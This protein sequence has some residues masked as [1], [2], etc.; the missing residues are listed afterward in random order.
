MKSVWIVD[1]IDSETLDVTQ[2]GK[3]C[4]T[5]EDAREVFTEALRE[6]NLLDS[7]DGIAGVYNDEEGTFSFVIREVELPE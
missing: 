7:W 2:I 4:S 1:F 3:T 5:Y 6:R